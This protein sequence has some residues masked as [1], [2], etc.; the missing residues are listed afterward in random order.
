MLILELGF[1][2]YGR[3]KSVVEFFKRASVS[4]R[5]K[6]RVLNQKPKKV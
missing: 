5:I 3:I 6:G 1:E 2:E 4:L